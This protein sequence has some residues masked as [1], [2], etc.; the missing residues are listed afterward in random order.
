[1]TETGETG[2]RRAGEGFAPLDAV[3]A[4]KRA[5]HDMRV[6][7]LVVT[8]FGDAIVP[9]GGEVWLGTLLELVGRLGVEANALRTAMSRLTAEGWLARTRIGR[10]SYYRLAPAGAAEFARATHRIYA[11]GPPGWSGAWLMLV[12]PRDAQAGPDLAAFL[13]RNAFAAPAPGLHFRPDTAPEEGDRALA[14]RVREHV[15]GTGFT[16][17]KG[18]ALGGAD[19]AALAS[20]A[21]ALEELAGDYRALDALFAGVKAAIDAG[22]RPGALDAMAA[23]TLLIHY[24]RRIVLKDPLLPEALLPEG[25]PGTDARRLVA[26]LYRALLQPSERWLDGAASRNGGTLKAPG[27][28]FFR[29]FGG[30]SRPD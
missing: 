18:H 11:A 21:W 1:M 10:N 2:N 15:A 12:A 6:W 22:E 5:E 27:P 25:W 16:L 4:T 19:P 7:S 23:R 8:I 29:R 26:D 17:F 3:I 28:A 13:A 24:F 9:R 20:S 30:L 14:D